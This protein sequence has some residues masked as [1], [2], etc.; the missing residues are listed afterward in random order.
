MPH[1]L[2]PQVSL[3]DRA[4]FSVGEAAA[5]AGLS[6]SFLYLLIERGTLRSVKLG[7]RRLIPREALQELLASRESPQASAAGTPL[8]KGRSPRLP[9]AAHDALR[10][11]SA[12][13]GAWR[14]S[15]SPAAG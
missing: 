4:C 12:H 10:T 6:V 9:E 8:A 13:A 1:C 7:A 5:L 2:V 15:S 3:A 11:L 14:R